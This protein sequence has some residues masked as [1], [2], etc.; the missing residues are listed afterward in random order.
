M[1]KKQK[2]FT[3]E[4]TGSKGKLTVKAKSKTSKTTK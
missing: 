2:I 4:N 1:R 3:K